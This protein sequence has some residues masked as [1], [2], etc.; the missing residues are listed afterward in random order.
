LILDSFSPDELAEK[1]EGLARDINQR[2]QMSKN[3]HTFAKEQFS[4]HA[5]VKNMDVLYKKLLKDV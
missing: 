2:R 3:A 4:Y 1:I 5:L